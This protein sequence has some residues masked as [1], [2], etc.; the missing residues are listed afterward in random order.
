MAV[1]ANPTKTVVITRC[2]SDLESPQ[3]ARRTRSCSGG[4][5]IFTPPTWPE[6]RTNLSPRVCVAVVP[7]T[8]RFP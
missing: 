4:E 2:R 7:R 3:P 5:H 8:V 1:G 6:G